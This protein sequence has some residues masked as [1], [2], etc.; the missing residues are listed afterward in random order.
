MALDSDIYKQRMK[1]YRQ[2]FE[3]AMQK[4]EAATTPE[5]EQAAKEELLALMLA[6]S[7]LI[8]FDERP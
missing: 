6:T 1:Q 5:Q 4:L 3:D 7:R 2:Q 8:K